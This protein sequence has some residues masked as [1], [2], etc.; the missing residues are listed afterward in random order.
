MSNQP[1][2]A[3]GG[4]ARRGGEVLSLASFVLLGLPDGMLGTAWPAMRV[5]FA[6]PIGGLGLILLAATGGS[7]AVTAFAGTL[8]RRLGVPALLTA[9]GLSAA[10][11]AAGYAL[12]PGLGLVVGVAVLT[13]VAAGLMDGGLNTAIALAGRSRLLNLLHGDRK[14]VV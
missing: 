8:I 5:T 10:A 6:A 2:P 1:P 14:S 3:P 4:P 9:A 12:A 13:G 7:I 11:G